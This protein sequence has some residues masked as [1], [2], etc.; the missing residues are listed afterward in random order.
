MKPPAR[1][2]EKDLFLG[3]NLPSDPANLSDLEKRHLPV[4]SAPKCVRKGTP[5]E[6]TVEVGGLLAHPNEPGHFIQFLEL[7]ADETILARMDMTAARACPR[8]TLRV[9]LQHPAK[10]LCAR[11]GCNLHGIWIGQAPI[12]VE[13]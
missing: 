8:V 1:A 7:W 5:F 6:V 3:T 9:T 12:T 13:V 11:S 10:E 2:G 4:I